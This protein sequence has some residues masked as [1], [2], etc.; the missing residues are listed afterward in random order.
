MAFV[1]SRTIGPQSTLV[2]GETSSVIDS[3]K[4]Q[5]GAWPDLVFGFGFFF[6]TRF[7]AFFFSLRFG[8]WTVDIV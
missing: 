3:I 2:S 8:C 5:S 7:L 1:D 4:L 6:A